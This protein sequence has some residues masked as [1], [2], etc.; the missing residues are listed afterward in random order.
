MWFATVVIARA[1]TA[2]H[3]L[4][5]IPTARAKAKAVDGTRAADGARKEVKVGTL[6][7]ERAKARAATKVKAKEA[8]SLACMSST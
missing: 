2:T 4:L 8:A 5:S 1:T 3:A 6:L 7:K